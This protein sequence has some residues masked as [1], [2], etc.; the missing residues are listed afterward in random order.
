[1]YADCLAI[2]HL[3]AN[4]SSKNCL[5]VI[6]YDSNDSNQYSGNLVWGLVWLGEVWEGVLGEV[7]VAVEIHLLQFPLLLLQIVVFLQILGVPPSSCVVLG[8]AQCVV[9]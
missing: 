7:E 2:W 4:E 8:T 6:F 1:M 3:K 5:N 9:S